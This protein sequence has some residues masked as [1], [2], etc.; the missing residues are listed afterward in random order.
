MHT[1]QIFKQHAIHCYFVLN[2]TILLTLVWSLMRMVNIS[3]DSTTSVMTDFLIVNFPY[4]GI[5][6]PVSQADTLCSG[7]FKIWRFSVQMIYSRK[8]RTTF[9]KLYGLHT[10]LVHKFDTS[11]SHMLNDLFNCDIGLVSRYFCCSSWRVPRTGNA[12]S[13]RNTWFHCIW[14]VHDFTHSLCSDRPMYIHIVY[15]TYGC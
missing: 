14:G 7:L 11:V 10:D 12:H 6:I 5:N 4:V 15:W 3:H 9:R 13:L 2:G 1:F 8:L